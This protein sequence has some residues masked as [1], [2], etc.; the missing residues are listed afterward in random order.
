MGVLVFKNDWLIYLI[1]FVLI[2]I[3]NGWLMMMY[4]FYGVWMY[5]WDGCFVFNM[6]YFVNNLGMVFGIMI[7]GLFY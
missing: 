7:V 3:V 5:S 4:N 6:F 2:G 1:M